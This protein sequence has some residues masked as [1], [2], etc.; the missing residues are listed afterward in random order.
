MQ[1]SLCLHRGV[2]WVGRHEKTAHVQAFDLDGHPLTSGFSFRDPRLGRSQATGIA[3]DEDRNLWVADAPASR[4]RRFT[5]FGLEIGGLGLAL[6]EAPGPAGREDEAGRVRDPVDVAVRG[7]GDGLLLA[8][9]S[10]GERRHAVQLFDGEGRLLSSLR[11]EGDPRGRFRGVRGLALAGRHVLVAEYEAQRVQVFRDGE[12]HFSFHPG[13]EARGGR[14]FVADERCGPSAVVPVGDGR[15]VV[16]MHGTPS[17]LLLFDGAGRL[18]RRLAEHGE[19]EGAVCHPDDV[20]LEP[21][22]DDR[23]SRLAVIDKDGDRVQ[24]FDLA[25]RALGTFPGLTG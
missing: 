20:V 8:V 13:A 23:A 15:M 5:A 3:V 2:L 19:H 17:S 18:L 6:D 24:L 14:P 16:A 1:G 4:V 22:V 9:A 11:P 10:G 12:H 21:G 7:D 25:G